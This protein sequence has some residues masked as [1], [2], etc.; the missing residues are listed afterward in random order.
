MSQMN[1]PKS[2]GKTP[3]K[4]IASGE[5]TLDPGVQEWVQHCQ[6]LR[7]LSRVWESECYWHELDCDL[8]KRHG[9]RKPSD[10]ILE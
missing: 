2:D 1:N 8:C 3:E 7:S 4:S 10:D 6:K 9:R 5:N